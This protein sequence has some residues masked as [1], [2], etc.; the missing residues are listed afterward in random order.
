MIL[1]EDILE[2]EDLYILGRVD[3]FLQRESV[4]HLTAAKHLIVLI[5]QRVS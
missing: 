3:D 2:N 4:S 1:S 5:A